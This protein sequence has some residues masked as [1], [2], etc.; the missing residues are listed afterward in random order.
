MR[1]LAIPLSRSASARHV[2]VLPCIRTSVGAGGGVVSDTFVSFTY[3]TQAFAIVSFGS[4]AALSD[5]PAYFAAGSASP[6]VNGASHAVFVG[7]GRS[8][9]PAAFGNRALRQA[10]S[11]GIAR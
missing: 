8:G 10:S 5:S 4:H 11:Q 2:S 3:S 7:I 1:K 6:P 9:S